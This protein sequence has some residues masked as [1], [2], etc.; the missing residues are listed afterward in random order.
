MEIEF[1]KK[2]YNALNAMGVIMLAILFV[3]GVIAY[4][5]FRDTDRKGK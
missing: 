1:L 5:I 2:I 4:K 3:C